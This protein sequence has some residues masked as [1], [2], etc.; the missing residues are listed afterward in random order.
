MSVYK[1][2]LVKHLYYIGYKAESDPWYER[3]CSVCSGVEAT[4][5]SAYSQLLKK[6]TA[7]QEETIKNSYPNIYRDYR[8]RLAIETEVKRAPLEIDYETR[9]SLIKEPFKAQAPQIESV[10]S[11]GAHLD[12]HLVLSLI[13]SILAFIGILFLAGNTSETQIE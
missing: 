8:E 3:T 1:H 11:S 5:I 9:M 13:M 2:Q 6:P 7:R 10:Y 4:E 12:R